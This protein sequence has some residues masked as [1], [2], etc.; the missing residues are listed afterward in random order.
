MTSYYVTLIAIP[1]TVN[2]SRQPYTPGMPFSR[3]VGNNKNSPST[4]WMDR[5]HQLSQVAIFLT[6]GMNTPE[7]TSAGLANCN[8]K[9]ES[10]CAASGS[11]C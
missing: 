8:Y 1:T 11:T 3:S 6:I 4:H 7:P 9:A 10:L 5:L 2:A